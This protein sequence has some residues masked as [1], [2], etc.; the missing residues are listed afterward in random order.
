M[1]LDILEVVFAIED[2]FGIFINTDDW[3]SLTGSKCTGD[4]TAGE[5][6]FLVGVK[7]REAGRSV[8]RSCWNGIRVELAKAF[9]IS[10]CSISPRF[11]VMRGT[12]AT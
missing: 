9:G 3:D 8:P 7:L 1:G 6:H 2:R 5:L 11:S 12:E 4:F 10:A